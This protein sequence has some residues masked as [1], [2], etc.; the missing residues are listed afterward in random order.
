[1]CIS[2]SACTLHVS[3]DPDG[4][5]PDAGDS[6]QLRRDHYEGEDGKDGGGDDNDEGDRGKDGNS[7]AGSKNEGACLNLRR[8]SLS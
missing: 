5:L 6:I 2:T 8:C 3:S 1:M 7:K 4:P